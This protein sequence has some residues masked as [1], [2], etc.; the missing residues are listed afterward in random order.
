MEGEKG[1]DGVFRDFINGIKFMMKI[2]SWPETWIP[3]LTAAGWVGYMLIYTYAHSL[4]N[5]WRS[6]IIWGMILILVIVTP[7][8]IFFSTHKED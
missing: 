5:P 4:Q 8:A 3:M 6:I 1:G 2:L 7:G